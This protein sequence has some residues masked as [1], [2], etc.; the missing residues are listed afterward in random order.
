MR[1]EDC[2]GR[3]STNTQREEVLCEKL[4]EQSTAILYGDAYCD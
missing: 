1:Q 2:F 3:K 4:L